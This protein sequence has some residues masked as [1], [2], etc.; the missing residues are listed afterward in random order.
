MVQEEMLQIDGLTYS[1][2][3]LNIAAVGTED[4]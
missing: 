4:N 3:R 1:I 2:E